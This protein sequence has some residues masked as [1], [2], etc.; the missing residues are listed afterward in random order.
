MWLDD[1]VRNLTTLSFAT[2]LLSLAENNANVQA[3][4]RGTAGEDF[5][6]AVGKVKPRR[7]DKRGMGRVNFDRVKKL[8]NGKGRSDYFG[9]M[10]GLV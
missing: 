4:P 6:E 7:N 2:S 10:L 3:H 1:Y 9:R 5:A 8:G